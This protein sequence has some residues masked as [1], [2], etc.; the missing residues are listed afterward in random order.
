VDGGVLK[1]SSLEERWKPQLPAADG[2]GATGSS[3]QAGLSF[4]LERHNGVDLV[5][6]SGDQ[7]GFI[8]HLY[9]H[10]QSRTAYVAS[11]NTDVAASKT[12]STRPTTRQVDAAVRDA[13]IREVFAS[14]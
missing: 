11:F 8:S 7:N 3:A 1:R 5:G 9:V 14:R 4:F 13:I 6:H 10:R 2:E 12:N